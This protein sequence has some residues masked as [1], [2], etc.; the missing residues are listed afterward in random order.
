MAQFNWYVKELAIAKTQFGTDASRQAA[1][2]HTSGSASLAKSYKK[3]KK[4]R[5]RL[6]K[7]LKRHQAKLILPVL[8]YIA[9]TPN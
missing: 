8:S 4:K 9:K 6:I 3:K 2:Q 5:K 7:K 1:S